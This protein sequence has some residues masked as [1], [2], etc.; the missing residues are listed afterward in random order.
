MLRGS[1]AYASYRPH[2]LVQLSPSFHR[3]SLTHARVGPPSH[4]R[5]RVCPITWLL[6]WS[7]R[8]NDVPRPPPNRYPN[9]A[10]GSLTPPRP[11]PDLLNVFEVFLPQ[12]LLYPNPADPLNGEAASMLMREPERYKDKIRG[13]ARAIDIGG[14]VWHVQLVWQCEREG[15]YVG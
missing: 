6:H 5:S 10:H 12:L 4:S 11:T 9:L 1:F 8:R 2:P 13:K 14:R 7:S 3:C 15:R